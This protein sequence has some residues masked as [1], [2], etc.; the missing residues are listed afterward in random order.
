MGQLVVRELADDSELLAGVKGLASTVEVVVAHAV[1]V[2]ITTVGVTLASESVVGVSTTALVSLADMVFV[3]SARVRG[4]SE[5]VRVR[6]PDI[7]LSTTGTVR[8]NTGVRVVGGRLP[9]LNVGLAT[10]ELQVTGAL[11]VTV[12][13]TVLGTGLV[14]GVAGH[15]TILLHSDEVESG[16]K[17]TVDGGEVDIEGELVALEGEGLVLVGAVHQVESGTDVSA[18]VVLGK[19]LKGESIAAGGGTVGLAVVGTLNSALG[20]AVLSGAALGSPL[21]AVVAVC[22]ALGGVKPSPVRVDG[23]FGV[24]GGTGTTTGALLPGELGVSLS[25]LLSNLLG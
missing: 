9:S 10:D 8:A 14:G 19:E 15:A 22:R 13:G 4:E 20:G 24:G 25:L 16:V 12:T 7:D 2:V 3:V 17:T 5:G 11:G 6:L 1:R 21:V 18:V 23:H